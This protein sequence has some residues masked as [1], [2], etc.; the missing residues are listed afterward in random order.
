MLCR[1]S[2]SFRPA[3]P[4]SEI[5][6]VARDQTRGSAIGTNEPTLRSFRHDCHLG[7]GYAKAG[8]RPERRSSGRNGGRRKP[9]F[10]KILAQ[11]DKSQQ[12]NIHE[13]WNVP[14]VNNRVRLIALEL[15]ERA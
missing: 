5:V 10:R 12:S 7:G 6:R 2:T 15:F 8:M 13:C 4:K 3:S 9:P 14:G 11:S 1:G